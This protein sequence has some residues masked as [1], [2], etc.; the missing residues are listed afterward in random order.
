ME[1]G[2]QEGSSTST[3]AGLIAGWASCCTLYIC[4]P[5]V[6]TLGTHV[7]MYRN[8]RPELRADAARLLVLICPGRCWQQQLLLLPCLWS[9]GLGT[10]HACSREPSMYCTWFCD[11]Y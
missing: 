9:V 6:L 10:W 1:C 7:H 5:A 11:V 2:A 8:G 4:W 3:A